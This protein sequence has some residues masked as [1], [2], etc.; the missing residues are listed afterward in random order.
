VGKS[1]YEKIYQEKLIA[2]NKAKLHKSINEYLRAVFVWETERFMVRVDNM[3]EEGYRYVSWRKPKKQN[4]EPDLIIMN[5]S[6]KLDGTGGNHF[7]SF[8]NGDYEYI[9]FKGQKYIKQ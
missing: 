5:G 9:C 3:G 1:E 2:K 7:Y 4:Q 6:K 8:R